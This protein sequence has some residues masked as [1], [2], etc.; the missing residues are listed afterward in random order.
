[1]NYCAKDNGL[2][3]KTLRTMRYRLVFVAIIVAG[4][5]LGFGLAIAQRLKDRMP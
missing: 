3:R 1:M 4:A 5:I 2:L